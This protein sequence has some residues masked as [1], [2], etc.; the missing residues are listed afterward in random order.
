MKKESAATKVQ[1]VFRGY[2]TRN[3]YIKM[4]VVAM[5]VQAAIRATVAC[6]E[7]KHRK[8]TKA[9]ATIQ[10]DIANTIGYTLKCRLIISVVSFSSA[11]GGVIEINRIIGN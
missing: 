5:T 7:F 3:A 8:Q 9:A 4:K 11:T 6:N 2:S 10:V 1:T